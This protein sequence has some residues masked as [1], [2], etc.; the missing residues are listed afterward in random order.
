MDKE[1]LEKLA[2]GLKTATTVIGIITIIDYI[3]PDPLFGLDEATL[4][5]ITGLLAILAKVN[6]DKLEAINKGEK[7]KITN[8]DVQE[9]TNEVGKVITTYKKRK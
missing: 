7:A 6:L 5:A 2:N 9:I 4:T 1:K 8:D 3:I